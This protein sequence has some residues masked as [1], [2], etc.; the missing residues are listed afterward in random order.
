MRHARAAAKKVVIDYEVLPPVTDPFKALDPDAPQVHAKGNVHEHPNHLE[1][2]EFTR[3]NVD[4]ALAKAAHVIEETFQTQAVEVAFLEPEACLALP[5]GKGVKVFSQH[6]GSV[7]DHKHIS[8]ILNLP[9]Q[10]VEIELAASGGAFGAKEDL[11]IQGQTARCRILFCSGRSSV[12]L[13][14]RESTQHHVK[15]HAMTLKLTVGADADGRLL[16]VRARIVADAGGT[17][18][19]S[20]KCALRAAC[21]STGVYRMPNVDVKGTAVFTNNPDSGAMRGFG[22]NQAQFAMEGVMDMLAERVGVDGWDIR[23]RNILDPGDEYCT[24][25]IMRESV[26]GARKSLEAVKDLYRSAKYAASAVESRAPAS[27]MA[28]PIAAT[29]CSKCSTVDASRFAPA[30]RRWGRASSTRLCR[31]FAK[32]LAFRP[33]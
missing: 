1:T 4:E 30:T 22:S 6:Q 28:S 32:K 9:I 29:S 3:G 10:D 21:H 13:T 15:R 14:R 19:E 33:M 8:R 16:A 2:T 17:P 24:G 23:E 27:A 26:R 25:Q 7:Y 18:H 11:T 20:A 5:Q 31:A 12:V